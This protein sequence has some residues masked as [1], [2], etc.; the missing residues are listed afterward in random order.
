MAETLYRKYR[1]NT[2]ADLVGQRHIRITL[3]HALERDRVSQ[4]YLFAGP[5]G[6]GKT[7]TA[8]LL[9]RA[10]NCTDRGTKAEPCNECAAC[11]SMIQQQTMDVVEIDAASQTGVDNVREHV[12]QSARSIPAQLKMKVFIIDEVHMLSTAAFNAL[13]K[14]LEEPPSHAMFILAT[15]EP[16]R[17]PETILS[18]LQRFDFQ[19]INFA[20]MVERLRFV[21]VGE[22]RNLE[23][24]VAERVARLSS[25][26]LR[27]AESM[28][29]QL[30]TIGDGEVTNE[31]ADVILPR[32]DIES[33]M[34]LLE[35]LAERRAGDALGILHGLAD[36]GADLPA[37]IRLV[38]ELTRA[39]MLCSVDATMI[40]VA[41]P[42]L[43][44]AHQQRILAVAQAVAPEGVATMLDHLLTAQREL[45]RADVELIP[46]EMAV[47]R[48]CFS[49]DDTSAPP[50]PPLPPRSAPPASPPS[51][52]EPPTTSSPTSTTPPPPTPP[53]PKR[54]SAGQLALAKVE[55]AW[56]AMTSVIASTSPG[57]ALSLKQAV[58][59]NAEN[60]QVT[61]AFPHTI[62]VDR[63]N[64]E[65]NGRVIRE[66][67]S[68]HLGQDVNVVAV[69]NPTVVAEL[70]SPSP[71]AAPSQTIAPVAAPVAVPVVA[72]SAPAPKPKQ[73]GTTGNDLWD[74]M[75]SSF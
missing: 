31:T 58:L 2:F 9:A 40:T 65:K 66:Q 43:D 74:Q 52:K 20:D 59:V 29:G 75:V 1:P 35:A 67:L 60:G 3:E 33:T 24:G 19:R 5:R 42:T 23:N 34:K 55:E 61:V 46:C 10:V 50:R 62:H 16:H 63:V 37:C 17:I 72:T 38:T 21:A 25:G 8:R 48:I 39:T 18:R 28:L 7:T 15:T 22:H 44:S 12:I 13:L 32:S 70:V 49:G 30:M 57:L 69:H 45:G 56:H 36:D 68:E 51:P 41:A 6:V 11:R 26:S 47:V 73:A 14:L 54:P 53:K 27:D 71:S 4:A 64:H